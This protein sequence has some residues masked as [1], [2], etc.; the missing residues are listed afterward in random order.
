MKKIRYRKIQTQVDKWK[1]TFCKNEVND[2]IDKL[3]GQIVI[4]MSTI[5]EF[6]D[7]YTAGHQKKVSELSVEIAKEMKLPEDRI[8]AVNVAGLLHD[9]GKISVPSEILT[10]PSKLIVP[11]FD[12]IKNHVE[13]GYEILKN[14]DFPWAIADIVSQHHERLNGSGYPY[15][16]LDSQIYLEAK[17]IAVADVFDAMSSHRPYRA[18]LGLE[19]TMNEL[20][21]GKGILYDSDVVDAFCSVIKKRELNNADIFL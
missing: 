21:S 6:R 17:I 19:V 11:E 9:I 14:I 3:I 20:I 7:M 16:L 4:T 8:H 2:Q 13:I 1:L 18:G 15:K 12:I 10:K 5:A